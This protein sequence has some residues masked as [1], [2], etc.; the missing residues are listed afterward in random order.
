MR[1]SLYCYLF[2]L[3]GIPGFLSGQKS[4]FDSFIS[5]L[6]E[7]YQVD[8]ALAPE[9]IPT[10]DSIKN[11]GKEVSTVEDFLRQML[12]DKHITYQ[13]LDGNKVLL[14]QDLSGNSNN[15]QVKIEGIIKEKANHLP[16]SYAAVNVL[17]SPRGAYTDESGH[18]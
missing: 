14:R 8:V 3:L 12:T 11:Y 13:I 15:G 4:P 18:F 17:N 9:L 16:L 2:I 6:T 10:L 1:L 5:V 7:R